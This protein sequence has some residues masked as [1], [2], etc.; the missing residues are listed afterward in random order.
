MLEFLALL[1]VFSPELEPIPCTEMVLPGGMGDRS[2]LRADSKA[3]GLE[4]LGLLSI[5]AQHLGIV[6]YRQLASITRY[7][8]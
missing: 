3:H 2:K 4:L 7:R 5:A 1:H 8:G 6:V